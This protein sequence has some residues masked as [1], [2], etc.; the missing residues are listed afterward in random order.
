MMALALEKRGFRVRHFA[1]A[2]TFLPALDEADD[3]DIIILDWHLPEISGIELLAEIRRRG[4]DIPVAFLTGRALVSYEQA[5][6]DKGAADFIDKARG[7][8][9]V[10]KRVAR[11]IKTPSKASNRPSEV[12]W[13]CAELTLRPGNRRAEWR[14]EDVAL[15]LS[16]YNVIALLASNAGTAVTYRAIYDRMHYVGFLAGDG[17]N[18]HMANVRSAMK[19]IRRKFLAVDPAFAEI[20]NQAGIGYCWRKQPSVVDAV[21]TGE[22]SGSPRRVLPPARAYASAASPQ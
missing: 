19:R 21:A 17:E 15:T 3:A 4:I 1:N 14:G 2:E 12:R 16:E 8:D 6:F 18:G 11:I 13:S 7:V 5:A 10:A 9:V 20:V 22:P